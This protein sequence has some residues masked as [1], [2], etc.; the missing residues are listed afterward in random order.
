MNWEGLLN[1][2][3]WPH[4]LG[5]W[6]PD[7]K[8]WAGLFAFLTVSRWGYC[9]GVKTTISHLFSTSNTL[10]PSSLLTA[11]LASQPH[12]E[13]R[14]CQKRT[15]PSSPL[16]QPCLSAA[17]PPVVTEELS[18]CWGTPIV[19]ATRYNFSH[20]RK[21]LFQI[22]Q[23]STKSLS[24]KRLKIVTASNFLPKITFYFLMFYC[25]NTYLT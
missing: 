22:S 4:L 15:G 21:K 25:D 13:N 5:S 8:G 17:F 7:K 18:L 3:G 2:D 1:T 6:I 20:L 11:D 19:I 12:W 14:I 16:F 23:L 9:A 24:T 10:S